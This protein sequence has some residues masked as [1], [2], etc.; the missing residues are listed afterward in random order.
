MSA[1]CLHVLCIDHDPLIWG[2][3]NVASVPMAGVLIVI[4]L[5]RTLPLFEG[6]RRSEESPGS[7][8]EKAMC[9]L[10]LGM[11]RH[12][13]KGLIWKVLWFPKKHSTLALMTSYIQRLSN[14][15]TITHN[16]SL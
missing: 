5:V 11:V 8:T 4:K 14:F 15:T 1:S 16:S 9:L 12:R 6:G 3:S 7:V 13:R 2:A 10:L